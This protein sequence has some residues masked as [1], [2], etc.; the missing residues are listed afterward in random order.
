MSNKEFTVAVAGAN[1]RLGSLICEVVENLSRFKLVTKF[2]SD[3][4]PEALEGADIVVDATNITASESI[5][6]EAIKNGQ[7]VIIATSGWNA[8]K[9]ELLTQT[10]ADSEGAGVLVVPNFSLGSVLA[11][12][13]A[14]LAAPFFAGVEVIET[15]HPKK[16]DSPSGTAVRTAELIAA[17]RENVSPAP[18][19]EQEA[20]GQNVAGI[21]V[22][23]LRLEGI[24]A[25]QEVRFGGTGE[26]VSIVHDTLSSDSYRA[27]ITAALK[28][29]VEV[30]GVLVG[31]QEILGIK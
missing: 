18:F 6:A 23:S 24:V 19:I 15:H 31:L 11:S 12:H 4:G 8:E 20:R 26:T 28:K 14:Q 5:V 21:P 30:D 17:A 9:I 10:V 13:L 2:G 3:S 7:K 25:K 22:H 1:G 16:I 29:V 27:G